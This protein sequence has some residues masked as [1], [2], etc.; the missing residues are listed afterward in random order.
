MMGYIMPISNFSDIK[1]ITKSVGVHFVG[2]A[3]NNRS[4]SKLEGAAWDMQA[5]VFHTY[6]M[7][8]HFFGHK[9]D[10]VMIL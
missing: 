8:T 2:A 5:F 6:G 10:S 3:F 4:N 7:D 1:Y 9:L